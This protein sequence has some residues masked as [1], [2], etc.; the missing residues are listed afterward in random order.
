MPKAASG[1][2]G[3]LPTRAK[4]FKTAAF[5]GLL[6]PSNHIGSI[7]GLYGQPRRTVADERIDFK[8]PAKLLKWPSFKNERVPPASGAVPYLICEGTFA[9]C[10]RKYGP[11]P[12]T[13]RH[14]YEIEVAL[15]PGAAPVA[16]PKEELAELARFHEFL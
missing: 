10:I 5:T 12:V 7:G 16:F 13:T 9:E 14:L 11:Y 4:R 15:K 2:I 1:S 6:S 8:A 3:V